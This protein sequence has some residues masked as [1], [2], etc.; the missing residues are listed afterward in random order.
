MAFVSRSE[1]RSPSERHPGNSLGPG[2]YHSVP[3]RSVAR[4]SRAPFM[5][6]SAR[7]SLLDA[8]SS[9]A[10]FNY[11]AIFPTKSISRTPSVHQIE[12]KVPVLCGIRELTCYNKNAKKAPL[13]S[14]LPRCHSFSVPSTIT[15]TARAVLGYSESSSA[16]SRCRGEYDP[17]NFEKHSISTPSLF[18]MSRERLQLFTSSS[19]PGPGCSYLTNP[20][21]NPSREVL[22]NLLPLKPFLR[23]DTSGDIAGRGSS[24]PIA[25]QVESAS[26]LAQKGCFS[27][28]GHTA[29]FKEPSK[30][31]P[32]PPPS[33]GDIKRKRGR[34]RLGHLPMVGSNRLAWNRRRRNRYQ[35]YNTEIY[36]RYLRR[37]PL[38]I[39]NK[40]EAFLSSSQ[41]SPNVPPKPIMPPLPVDA[42]KD[43][44][45]DVGRQ[46]FKRIRRN[47]YFSR[48]VVHPSKQSDR[49][50][51]PGAYEINS[52]LVKRSFNKLFCM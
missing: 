13:R 45:I 18:A 52:S 26:L 35:T 50:C 21:K 22:G 2:F 46:Y 36:M 32:V 51:G 31:L 33:S 38:H 23:D 28:S 40:N 3:G 5:S 7:S 14:T 8:C 47:S 41:R 24:F 25:K 27:F 39:P 20:P 16:C 12:L 17:D 1:R 19:G 9:S 4:G 11:S 30:T 15:K 29:R 10:D 49:T 37:K 48:E 42:P 6:T 44:T 43:D 34:R